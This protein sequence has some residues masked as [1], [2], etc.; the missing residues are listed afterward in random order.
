MFTL[1]HL[2][3]LVKGYGIWPDFFFLSESRVGLYKNQTHLV[4]WQTDSI[5]YSFLSTFVPLR[6]CSKNCTHVL[7]FRTDVLTCNIP[8]EKCIHHKYTAQINF[9]T[10]SH[11][12]NK[13][14]NQKT[15]QH[16]HLR[17]LLVPPPQHCLP[18]SN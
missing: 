10:W 18:Q 9:T 3:Y 15:E 12:C 2:I 14:P 11:P 13:H 7:H 8:T 4:S 5:Y 16:Q 1:V 17:N 6:L